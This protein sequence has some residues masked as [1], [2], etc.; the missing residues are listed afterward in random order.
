MAKNSKRNINDKIKKVVPDNQWLRN[1]T[2]SF[3][4]TSLDVVKSLLPDTSDT[5]EWNANVVINSMDMINNIRDNNGI[6][7]AFNK[8]FQNIPQI[9]ASK[10]IFK[11]AFDDI[12]T[13]NFYNK[14]R[15]EG[16]DDS[17]DDFGD[18]F[19]DDSGPQFID[20]GDDFSSEPQF[21]EDDS[22]DSSS[23]PPVAVISTMPLAKSIAA[24]TEATVNTMIA[25]SDQQMAVE[26]EKAMFT[27]RANGVFLNALTSINDNL[28]LLV[29]FNSDSTTKFHAAATE[30]YSQS[31]ELLKN[32]ENAGK[33]EEKERKRKRVLD[34]FTSSGGIKGDEYLKQ[35]KQNL[36]DIKDENPI[37]GNIIDQVLNVDV[38]TGIAQ[39]P[40]GTLVP[41]VVQGVLSETFKST[42]GAL[43]KRVNSVMPAI[44]ARINSFEDNDNTLLNGINKLFGTNPKVS[45]YVNLGDYEK[46]TITWDG[47]SKKALVEVI[48]TYLRRIESALTGREERI[49]DYDSGEFVPYKKLKEN[50]EKRL[51]SQYTSGYVN[52][53]TEMMDI[54]RKMN[55]NTK[56]LDQFKKDMEEYFT[57][58]TKQGH[59]I[60][61]RKYKK[62]FL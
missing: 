13:G 3:G 8:Q 23:R 37:I 62:R 18:M 43:D 54:V 57:V 58:M 60:N 41:M 28:A 56:D 46:G 4:F 10:M 20:E 27:Q 45:K 32:I 14:G 52:L 51:T 11:N 29:Q 33:G 47:E 39:N 25:I 55:L 16:T 6:R 42:L 34:M 59:R 35:L 61:H 15:L 1:A 48:P 26:T 9:K 17:F 21:S 22:S 36:I 19:G 49:Y 2:K 44:L 12:K 24:S 38:L 5:V 7:N 50:Y 53:E 31:I 40:I 30:Y